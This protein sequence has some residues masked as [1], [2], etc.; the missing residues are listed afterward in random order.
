MIR[1][2]LAILVTVFSLGQAVPAEQRPPL[3]AGMTPPSRSPAPASGPKK[4]VTLGHSLPFDGQTA[5]AA[6]VDDAEP[7]N[8][9]P[10]QAAILDEVEST[11]GRGFNTFTKDQLPSCADGQIHGPVPLG[12]KVDYT[13]RHVTSSEELSSNL[14][15]EASVK[16]DFATWSANATAAYNRDT[17]SDSKSDFVLVRVRVM[18]TPNV[19]MHHAKASETPQNDSPAAQQQ[20]FENCGDAF[21]SKVTFGGEFLALLK[22]EASN[23]ADRQAMNATVSASG[24]GLSANASL[25]DD[26]KKS[27]SRMSLALDTF[28]AGG[29]GGVAGNTPAAVMEYALGFA[30]SVTVDNAVMVGIET[31]PYRDLHVQVTDLS[32]L[33]RRYT[34]T[35]QALAQREEFLAFAKRIPAEDVK[36]GIGDI[37]RPAREKVEQEINSTE[38]YLISCGKTPFQC[39]PNPD[40]E[41]FARPPGV[42]MPRVFD[43]PGNKDDTHTITAN[44][45]SYFKVT[46]TVCYSDGGDMCFPPERH[47]DVIGVLVG[48]NGRTFYYTG[49]VSI[50]P[51]PPGKVNVITAKVLDSEY[52]DNR[53][54]YTVVLY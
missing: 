45:G 54:S 27:L 25:S 30:N 47:Q 42:E 3:P 33:T 49:P 18:L 21:I 15:A 52:S 26:E 24:L 40:L 13:L 28:V 23:E 22:Y 1:I 12:R 50:P 35:Q 10:Q 8:V 9:T 17:Q 32:E 20:F 5:G 31:A 38:A 48:L 43:L 19:T 16:G 53:G 11:F 39:P 29:S 14:S 37:Y 2:Q 4:H 6:E 41:R 44:Y 46:G 34:A 7:V 51:L 36:Y